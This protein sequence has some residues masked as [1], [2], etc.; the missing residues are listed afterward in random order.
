MSWLEELDQ[1][2]AAA[3]VPSG[4]RR[5]IVA[6]LADHLQCDPS[7]RERLGEPVEIAT[8][9]ANELGANLARRAGIDVFVALA[10]FGL[11]FGVV[12]ALF[13][14][15]GYGSADPTPT[16]PAVILGTQLAFV[17][18]VLALLRAWRLRSGG[19]VTRADCTIVIRRAALAIGGGALTAA[20]LAVAAA[21][22]PTHVSPWFVALV[23]ATVGVGAVGLLAATVSLARALR[24]RPVAPGPARGDLAADLGIGVSS[25]RIAVAIAVAVALCISVAG[26]A[27]DD[28]IDGLARGVADGVLCLAGFA[29]LGRPLG[30]RSYR[31]PV[32][33]MRR[34]RGFVA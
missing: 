25:T 11:L 33:A 26:I 15:A 14:A 16:G 9:F 18:G 31:A 10:P 19:A 28:P 5:R 24:L 1:A 6:E 7:S 20:G 23:Y 27:Q 21:Q 29:L 22:A 8:R 32:R 2:L 34:P 13:G 30:L 17:G 12:F 4:R 3:R